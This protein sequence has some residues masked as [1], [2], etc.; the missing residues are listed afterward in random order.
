[1]RLYATVILLGLS[2]AACSAYKAPKHAT[3]KNTTS[4]EEME[5][6]YWQAIKDKDW[7]NVEAHTASAYTHSS[8]AGVLNKQQGLEVLKS[9]DLVEF[10]LGDFEIIDHGNTSVLTYTA[11]FT[12]D[13]QGQ[14]MGPKTI[15]RMAVWQQ[16]K[17]G[18]AKIA[19][20][21]SVPASTP[22]QM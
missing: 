1:M 7:A 19:D 11:T 18:W 10:S 20:S 4:L 2:M 12:L 15:R 9:A 22:A 17:K 3:W 8:A 5:K 6:L 21:D 14:H 16:Q 13:Y